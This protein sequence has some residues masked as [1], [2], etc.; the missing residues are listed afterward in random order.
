VANVTA[1]R[2]QQR[3]AFE[4]FLARLAAHS[5]ISLEKDPRSGFALATVFWRPSFDGVVMG[6]R[7]DPRHSAWSTETS[8]AVK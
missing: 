2:L 7:W 1:Q 6:K 4:R 5:P 3:V 8:I